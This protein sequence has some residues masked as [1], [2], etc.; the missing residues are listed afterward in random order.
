MPEPTHTRYEQ[1]M[2]DHS[3]HPD[4]AAALLHAAARTARTAIPAD[5]EHDQ[6]IRDVAAGVAAPALIGA[7]FWMLREAHHSGLERLRFLSRDGQIFYELARRLAPLAG[8][9]LDMEYVY[10]SRMTWSLAATNPQHLDQ[11]SWLFNSFVKSNASDLCARLGLPADDYTPLLHSAGVS[12]DP[13]VRADHPGQADAM[14]RFLALPPVTE[15]AA[16]RIAHTR[17]LLIDYAAR[18]DLT[19]SRTGLIDAGW[20]G[21][22]V[23]SLLT[24]CGATDSGRPRVLFWGHE[25]RPTGGIDPDLVTAYMYNTGTGQGMN[26]RVP[27]APFVVETF[28]MGDHGIVT[29]YQ[30]S[31]TGDVEPIL[32]SPSNTAAEVWGLRTYRSTVYAVADEL[33]EVPTDDLRPLIHQ[34][35]V[36]FWRHPTRQEATTWG[37]YPYD[38][39]PTGTAARPLARPLDPDNPIRGDRAWLC[40]T[41]AL[42]TPEVH[43]QYLKSARDDNLHGAPET[44]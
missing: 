35:M 44:D 36:A 17:D 4:D 3:H 25:P 40:G 18:H 30:R 28:C 31:S 10:S 2:L 20:T 41:L 23:G 33:T 42:S 11:E 16:A 27:D 12:L 22:M 39:D 32:Q 8:V 7:T 19:D 5:T 9:D 43:S 21:R 26:F 14:R 34:I 24:A 15:A 37:K 1:I 13:D 38:S 29:G 6:A